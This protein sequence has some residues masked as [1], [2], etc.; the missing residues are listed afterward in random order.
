M[1]SDCAPQGILGTATCGQSTQRQ[2][3]KWL[4]K[5]KLCGQ[6]FPSK[7]ALTQLPHLSTQ[8]PTSGRA[9]VLPISNS[10]LQISTPE[11]SLAPVLWL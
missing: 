1:G 5:T 6:H 2:K 9:V 10:L 3:S 7:L 8:L 4:P 11:R